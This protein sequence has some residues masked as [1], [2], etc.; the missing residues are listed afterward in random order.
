MENNTKVSLLVAAVGLGVNQYEKSKLKNQP[1]LNSDESNLKLL[2]TVAV[3]G[4]LISA[5]IFEKF[6]DNAKAR[7]ISFIGLGGVAVLGVASIVYALK[8]FT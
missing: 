4:G 2:G 3:A 5:I 8:K 6:K 1:Y 7:K